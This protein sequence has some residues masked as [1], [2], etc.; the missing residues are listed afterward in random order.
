MRGDA[1]NLRVLDV[2]VL[3]DPELFTVLVVEP[4]C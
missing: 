4:T 3:N 1:P 2:V